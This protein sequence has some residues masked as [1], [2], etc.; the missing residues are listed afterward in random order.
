MEREMDGWLAKLAKKRG[1]GEGNWQ[2]RWFTL[3]GDML[4]FYNAE[5]EAQTKETPKWSLDLGQAGATATAFSAPGAPL[6]N[7]RYTNASRT[8]AEKTTMTVGAMLAARGLVREA[9]LAVE[10]NWPAALA[11]YVGAKYV[12]KSEA[13]A[14]AAG[15][16]A[17]KKDK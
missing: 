2:R 12:L 8:S 1:G 3:R 4:C 10:K 11:A 16:A 9:D 6:R 14:G 13:G 15:D 17:G 7:A 5:S